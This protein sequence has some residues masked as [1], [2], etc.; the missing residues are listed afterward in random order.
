M[1]ANRLYQ[2][3]L[4]ASRQPAFYTEMNIP[5][6]LDGRFDLAALHVCL[7]MD[8]LPADMTQPLFDA[9]FRAID[10]DLRE[11]GVDMS[12]R[13]HILKMMK[14]FNGRIHGYRAA[15]ETGGA[16]ALEAVLSRNVWRAEAALPAGAGRLAAYA[17][18]ARGMLASQPFE[19]LMQGEASFPDPAEILSTEPVRNTAHG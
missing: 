14:A 4:Q 12:V 2:R 8:R 9:M 1:A 19:V 3:A 13:K 10:I 17:M 7:L 16:A 18:S 6:T 5:D 11:Q 15:F